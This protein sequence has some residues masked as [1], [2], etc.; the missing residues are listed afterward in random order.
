MNDMQLNSISEGYEI[1][2]FSLFNATSDREDEIYNKK[3]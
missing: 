3:F 1:E 2:E